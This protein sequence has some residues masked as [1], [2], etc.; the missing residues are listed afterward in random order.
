MYDFVGDDS[1]RTQKRIAEAKRQ[2]RQKHPSLIE[3]R[4]GWYRAMKHQMKKVK[5]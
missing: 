4:S 1:M 2:L 3:N 5:I